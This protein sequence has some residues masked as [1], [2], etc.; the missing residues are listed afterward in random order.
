[1]DDL[2]SLRTKVDHKKRPF[3]RHTNQPVPESPPE[4]LDWLTDWGKIVAKAMLRA[5]F[6]REIV[7]SPST[8]AGDVQLRLAAGRHFV[9]MSAFHSDYVAC[10]IQ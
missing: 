9:P 3:W 10:S 8:R 7:P 6:S 5:A 2:R 1:M 4:P